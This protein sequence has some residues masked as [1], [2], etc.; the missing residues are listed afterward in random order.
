M[1]C[2]SLRDGTTKN[3]PNRPVRSKVWQLCHSRDG[4]WKQ[5]RATTGE[6][7]QASTS[8]LFDC[9]Q[10]GPRCSTNGVELRWWRGLGDQCWVQHVTGGILD[11]TCLTP[12]SGH[13]K[14]NRVLKSHQEKD[15][16]A[17]FFQAAAGPSVHPQGGCS[18]HHGMFEK[19]FYPWFLWPW[20]DGFRDTLW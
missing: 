10:V 8:K 15:H 3:L 11:P 9:G 14:R 2:Y 7:D 20:I 17:Q 16:K 19:W 13:T 1:H 6:P 18:S 5:P 12:L 4:R